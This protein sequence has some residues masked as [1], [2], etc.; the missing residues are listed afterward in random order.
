MNDWAW[1]VTK[2]WDKHK[3]IE[4]LHGPYRIL[5]TRTN[6]TVQLRMDHNVVR[7]VHIRQLR[8]YKGGMLNEP[9]AQ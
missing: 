5:E 2:D 7:S 6:G 8:P 3:M 1:R 9:L 4:R